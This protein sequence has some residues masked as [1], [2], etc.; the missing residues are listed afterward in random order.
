MDKWQIDKINELYKQI[1]DLSD[2]NMQLKHNARQIALDDRLDT[3]EHKLDVLI[4]SSLSIDE[5]KQAI[6][7]GT[8]TRK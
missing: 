8:R 6:K 4:E 3:I 5:I 1:D 7:P 2:Q